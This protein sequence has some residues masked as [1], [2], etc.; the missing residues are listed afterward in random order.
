MDINKVIYVFR[1]I[2]IG[3]IARTL[4]N[5]VYRS[6]NEKHFTTKSTSI[7]DEF[8]YELKLVTPILS[9]ARI[10]FNQANLE[11]IFLSTNMIRVSWGPGKPP[12]PYTINKNNW[13]M[14]EPTIETNQHGIQLNYEK[15]YVFIDNT[16]GIIYKDDVDT[17]LHTEN[18]PIRIGDCWHLTSLLTAEEHIYGLGER[19]A[20]FNI[21]P[22]NYC[23]WNTDIG[24]K[25]TTGTDPLYIGTPI[26]LSLSNSGSYLV[27]FE[28]SYRS[29]YHIS[30]TFAASFDGGMLRYYIIF[31]PLNTIYNQ[32]SELI[33]R[34]CMPPRWVFGYHQSRWGYRSET[35]IQNVVDGFAK[36]DFPLSAVHLDIDYMEGY[37]VFSINKKRFPNMHKLTDDLEK[38]GIKT[39]VS[40]NPAIKNDHKYRLFLDGLENDSFC[41]LP[42]GK[43]S[44]GV[45]WPGW[46]VFPDFSNEAVRKW[47]S[48]Q[49]LYLLDLGISGI[50]HDMNEPSSFSAW[51]EM[52]LPSST[53]HNLD[54]QIGNHREVHNLYGLL[55]NMACFEGL[56][57]YSPN[58]R[59]WIF[60]RSGW[61]GLQ[62]YAWNWTGDI[63]SSWTSL[64]QTIITILG[65]SLS[66]HAFS[67]A[68]IGGF[69]GSPDA[70]LYMRWF[71]LSAFLPLFRTHSAIGTKPREPWV[72][73]EPT[74]SIIRNFIKLR[75]SLIPYLYTLAWETTQTGT[76]PIRP[77][78]WENPADASLWEIDDE[79]FLGDAL[80][81]APVVTA[82]AQIR[83]IYLPE[84]LWYSFWDDK[85]YI[86]PDRFNIDINPDTIPVFIRGGTI[87]PLE[88]D[89]EIFLHLY[90][91]TGNLSS[92][93]I[94]FDAGDGYDSWRVDNLYSYYLSKAINISWETEG[95]YPFPYSNVNLI[96]HSGQLS[97]VTVD[98]S[99]ILHKNNIIST[100]IFNNLNLILV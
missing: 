21:R 69:S 45:S 33:G 75:Y 11:I 99:I 74:T 87:L 27:Y 65:L 35:D 60:S 5:S 58:K 86:G 82:G 38:K 90:P 18:P 29:S 96:F 28:N 64:K 51:G 57:K 100:P 91:N 17:I 68:D 13:E 84:G 9:G 61:A 42:N 78:F 44:G 40:I 76:P 37:R 3:G 59:P 12:V 98:G 2:G 30:D 34:P 19:A 73:G 39:V 93:H 20:S 46:S 71:Q 4:L 77:L 79:F 23:S 88:V 48:E 62:K 22:G 66:G 55:M 94:Y 31:G 49:Y 32:L 89:G 95:T 8:A 14:L 16:G 47:W 83:Q 92:S 67:G 36:H 1:S 52:T 7:G 25:Y 81:I 26:Y 56:Q 24:G 72:F 43:L 15:L 63:D 80:I 41:K 6:V 50:W 97:Q 70:E 53:Q 54:G 10:Q 85:V